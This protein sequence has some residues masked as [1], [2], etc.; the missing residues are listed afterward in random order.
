MEGLVSN[1]IYKDNN[2]KATL[3]VENLFTVKN[4]M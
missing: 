2:D 1:R 4:L 3:T